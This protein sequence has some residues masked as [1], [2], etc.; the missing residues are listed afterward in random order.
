MSKKFHRDVWVGLV[1]LL[2][3][4]AV[5]VNAVQI[6]GQAAYLP[7]ALTVLMAVC[8]VF[9]ILKG[10]RLTKEQMGEYSYPLTVKNSKYAFLF[11][12]FIFIYYLGFRYITY[13]IA[14]PI[15]M[16]FTQKY[17][18]LKSFKI[19]LLITVLYTILAFIVFVV[20]L[21]LPIY[22]IGILGRFFRYL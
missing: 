11:M 9:I 16:L 8:A 19:N 10:L 18:K 14:T 13:W 17:L 5:L 15:F 12:F 7:V 6:S 4:A 1:L 20:I 3:C 21:H 22:T 2:F